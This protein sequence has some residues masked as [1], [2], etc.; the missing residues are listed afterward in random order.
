MIQHLAQ[1]GML[2]PLVK[3][4]AEPVS[5]IWQTEPSA[6][7]NEPT[8]EKLTAA[9]EQLLD[10]LG[11]AAC[12]FFWEQGS[13]STGLVKDRSLNSAFDD[14]QVASIA[15]TGFGLTALCIADKHRFFPSDKVRARVLTTLKFLREKMLRER[16]FFFHFVNMDTGARVWN[17][18]ISSIDTGILLC[19]V[20]TCRQ[21]FADSQIHDLATEIYNRVDWAW[22]LD[23][24][25][26][27]SHGWTPEHGFLPYRWNSYSELMMIY[28]LGIGSP[29]HP[30]PQETWDA[31]TRPIFNYEGLRY[32]GSNAPL[33]VHQ[34]SQAWFDFRG[35][36]DKYANY[37]ENSMKA[38]KAHRLFCIRLQK[39]F[40]D[41]SEDLWGITASD[42]ARGYVVWG[43][44]PAMGPI[45]GTLVSA[46]PAGSLPFLPQETLQVLH[47]MRERFGA[48]AWKRYGFVDAFNPLKK[49]YDTQVVGIDTGI[50]LLM[51]ENL[52]SGFVWDAFMKNEEAQTGM[53][54]AG[55]KPD[56]GR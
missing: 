46:A 43:G 17:S 8:N 34:Y 35:K 16:G 42:S 21:Y 19:G 1:I 9:D 2:S 27:L 30:I 56:T 11:K 41:Y 28:L 50:S 36:R 3:I 49:W 26:T 54:R 44:P 23:R 5:S 7:A 24:G 15:A 22:M 32:I 20:L 12:L 4:D 18:E 14:H 51:A 45:D 52:R 33:F 29:T 40:P 38:T 39:A 48:H 53:K 55:F 37:F 25:R 6:T 10:E 47:A 31:W 13:P